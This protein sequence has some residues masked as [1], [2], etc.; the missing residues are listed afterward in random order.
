MANQTSFI[1]DIDLDEKYLEGKFFYDS[2]YFKKAKECFTK[3]LKKRPFEKDYWFSF[4]AALQE[5]KDFEK[6][7]KAW[8][9]AIFLDNKNPYPYFHKAE[10]LLSLQDKK[11]AN[12]EL[13]KARE[14]AS[15]ALLEKI[16][17]LK[18]Q[19]I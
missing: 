15:N 13:G 17:I 1:K 14:F 18:N 3:L 12:I 5:E 4:S 9:I 6:A 7:I 8:D 2:G 11:R 16:K 19:N 10:C